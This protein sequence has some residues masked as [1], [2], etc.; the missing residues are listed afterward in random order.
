MAKSK[1][2]TKRLVGWTSPIWGDEFFIWKGEEYFPVVY[3]RKNT[4]SGK[5]TKVRITIEEMN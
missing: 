2:K 4:S 1:K 5:T 3:E